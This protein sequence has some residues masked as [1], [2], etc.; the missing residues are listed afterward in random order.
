M[1]A[2]RAP[3]GVSPQVSNRRRTS[4]T[5]TWRAAGRVLALTLPTS[6]TRARV[7]ALI[8]PRRQA[9][10]EGAAHGCEDVV[11]GGRLG[12]VVDQHRAQV[13]DVTTVDSPRPVEQ[14]PTQSRELCVSGSCRVAGSLTQ[15]NSSASRG[16]ATRPGANRSGQGYL[17]ARS[18]RRLSRKRPGA[19]WR[20]RQGGIACHAHGSNG[21][22]YWWAVLR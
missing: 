17:C 5:S 8:R 13:H 3:L 22:S 20:P 9:S 6:T 19:F 10:L 16:V 4:P 2:S 21:W 15:Y 14:Y 12:A 1:A 11:D 18:T 7:S